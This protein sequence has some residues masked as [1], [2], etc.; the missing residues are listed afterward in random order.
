MVPYSLLYAK[1]DY[2]RISFDVGGRILFWF[3]E[4]ALDSRKKVNF[5]FRQRKQCNF[6][7]KFEN[8]KF[9]R[10]LVSRVTNTETKY[11]H[12]AINLTITCCYRNKHSVKTVCIRSFSGP[13]SPTFG[14]NSEIYEVF[15]RILSECWKIRTRKAQNTDSFYVVKTFGKI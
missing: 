8:R 4:K 10:F 5:N 14:L 11:I 15:L 7:C 2:Y 1:L 6:E 9:L 12:R 3:N 13:Y